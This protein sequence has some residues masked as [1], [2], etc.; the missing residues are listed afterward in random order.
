MKGYTVRG[1]L[2]IG[3]TVG[4]AVCITSLGLLG[5]S[6]T[7]SEPVSEFLDSATS[8]N[9]SSV[10]V[11]VPHEYEFLT[12]EVPGE[13]F[14]SEADLVQEAASLLAQQHGG[15]DTD[16]LPDVDEK[17]WVTKVNHTPTGVAAR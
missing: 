6:R 1:E 14:S 16:Y 8:E 4:V 15:N 13:A 9:V 17:V 12:V 2:F 11:A 10:E 7:S 5:A 3:S